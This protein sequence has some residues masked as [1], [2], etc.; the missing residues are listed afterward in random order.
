MECVVA[1]EF[2]SGRSDE[3]VAKE[4]AIAWNNVMQLHNFKRPYSP[5]MPEEKD[6]NFNGLSTEDGFIDYANIFTVLKEVT[7]NFA[8]VYSYGSNVCDFLHNLL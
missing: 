8:H 5:Y 4:V 1:I 7:I 2:L 3:L 6:A